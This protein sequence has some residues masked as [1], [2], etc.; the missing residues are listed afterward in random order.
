MFKTPAITASLAFAIVACGAPSTTTNETPAPAAP[1]VSEAAVEVVDAVAADSALASGTFSG[2]SD[3]ITTGGVSLVG[4]EGSYQLVFAADFSLDG[5]PDPVVGFGT[6]GTYD[7]ATSLG[8]LQ[9]K[10]GAQTYSLPAD[11]SPASVNE[12][13]VW[14]DQFSVPLGVASLATSSVGRGS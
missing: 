4:T 11:F 2:L 8:D 5:A 1:A 7:A 3:H 10:T 6:D 9:N 14:C 13:Y 12:V